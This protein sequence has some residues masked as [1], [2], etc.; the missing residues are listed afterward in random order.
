[1]QYSSLEI[2]KEDRC[3]EV[4]VK[5]ERIIIKRILMCSSVRKLNELK[6]LRLEYTAS[7]LVKAVIT[8]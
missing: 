5:E 1:M 2:R 3:V 4:S 7:F 8:L 6:W